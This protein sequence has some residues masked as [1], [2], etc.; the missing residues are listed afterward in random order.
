MSEAV[1]VLD[2]RVAEGAVTVRDLGPAGMITL[3]GDLED[4]ALQAVCQELTGAAFPERRAI[5]GG[6]H[7]RIGWM[8]PDEVLLIMA[9][10][11]VA[12]ALSRIGTALGGAH[13]LAVDV[14]D[15]RA[16]I[17]LEGAGARDVLAKVAPV[18]LRPESLGPGE[19]R[20]TRLGQVAAAFWIEAEGAITVVCF[21][22][23]ADYVFALL[24][25]SAADPA[26]G[27]LDPA[28]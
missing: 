28:G 2:G 22:S 26:V 18:D 20:R 8:S 9:P 14:S 7:G 24:A 17:A 16:V 6:E 19:L 15:M 3:R 10:E 25:R 5:T 21:R 27:F 13:H 4:A 11:A 1:S 23:V 12:D